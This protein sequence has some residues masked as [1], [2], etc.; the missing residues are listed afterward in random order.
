[1]HP[2]PGPVAILYQAALP[3]PVDG[4]QKPMKP[5]GYSDSGA[6]IGFNLR[7]R[8]MPLVT[9]RPSPDPTRALDW[10]FPDTAEGIREACDRGAQ[11]LWANTVLFAGHPLEQLTAPE[12]RIVGQKPARAQEFDDKWAT[13]ERLREYGCSVP[14]AALVGLRPAPGVLLPDDLTEARLE[15]CRL[16]LPLVV[17]PV[18][19]RGSEGVSVSYTVPELVE[20]ARALLSATTVVGELPQPK[21]GERVIVEQ[22]LPGTELTVTVMPPGTYQLP[23]GERAFD[24]H[25]CLPPV[26]RFNHLQGVAPYNGV[27]AVTRN[28]VVLSR[29][30]RLAEGVQALE[31][32]CVVAAALVDAVAP[33]RIDARGTAGGTLQLFDLNMKPNLTGAGR[34]GRD[35][36]DSLTTMAARGMG[37]S[38]ASLLLNMLGQAWNVEA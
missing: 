9:P 23:E 21:Y 1:M 34:P 38:Y 5:G 8:G 28:S 27:V 26:R 32:Q 16:R 31:A 6:D 14:P 3:P 24:R 2:L 13:N 15:Q 22:F 4:V 11:V 30:E 37:W 7:A 36:Q 17:K 35:D 25:W 18:R 10:V 29:E 20:A 12:L 33:I 19:G